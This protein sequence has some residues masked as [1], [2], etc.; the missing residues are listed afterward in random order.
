MQIISNF[1]DAATDRVRIAAR[2]IEEIATLKQPLTMERLN[3]AR[4]CALDM[5]AVW[6]EWKR[7]G[8]LMQ[9]TGSNGFIHRQANVD[10][11][12]QAAMTSY[13]DLKEWG[14]EV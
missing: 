5:I 1:L 3:E 4:D 10:R 9:Q 7:L 13:K 14:S 12:Y 8:K 11:E 2:K 6:S